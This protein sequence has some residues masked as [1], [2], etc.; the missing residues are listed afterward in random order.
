MS[1]AHSQSCL[2]ADGLH[3]PEEPRVHCISVTLE[4]GHSVR[5][6]NSETVCR[7]QELFSGFESNETV[8]EIMLSYSGSPGYIADHAGWLTASPTRRNL[9]VDQTLRIKT[10]TTTQERVLL[11]LFYAQIL[12]IHESKSL[13]LLT[14]HKKKKRAEYFLYFLKLLPVFPSDS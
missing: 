4:D 2:L 10:V 8:S 7:A 1:G 5:Y 6:Q 11:Y 3:H 14:P 13:S 12:A 9:D